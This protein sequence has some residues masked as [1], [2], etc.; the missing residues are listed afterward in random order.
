LQ[1]GKGWGSS[2]LLDFF[3]PPPLANGSPEW[4]HEHILEAVQRRLDEHPEQM[5]QRRETVEHH[6]GTIN[7]FRADP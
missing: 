4:E 5:R 6:F 7:E 3:W 2:T 1:S